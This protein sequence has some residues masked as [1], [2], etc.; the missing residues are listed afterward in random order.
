[1]RNN[2]SLVGLKADDI[3][4]RPRIGVSLS[5]PLEPLKNNVRKSANRPAIQRGVK[6]VD[7]LISR[8]VKNYRQNTSSGADNVVDAVNG[9]SDA[10]STCTCAK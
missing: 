6:T 8:R 7:R 1:M 4:T 3:V 10:I 9:Y 2:F 5:L